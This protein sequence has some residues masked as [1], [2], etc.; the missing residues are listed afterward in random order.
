MSPEALS[1]LL[2]GVI[3]LLIAALSLYLKSYINKKAEN[4]ATKKDIQE[5]TKTVEKTK[6]EFN[7]NLEKLKSELMLITNQTLSLASEKRN[8]I[9]NYNEEYHRWYNTTIDLARPSFEQEDMKELLRKLVDAKMSYSIASSKIEIFFRDRNFIDVKRQIE[10]KT[11]QLSDLNALCFHGC[12]SLMHDRR[13]NDIVDPLVD[14]FDNRYSEVAKAQI[15]L[16]NE[17]SEKQRKIVDEMQSD[18]SSLRDI[19]Y[20]YITTIIK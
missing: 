5:L 6:A 19:L 1:Q 4:E 12:H 2:S 13:I 15:G 3:I 8:A 18:F 9:Y 20:G 7:V 11:Q 16:I 14:P 17:Y 10:S